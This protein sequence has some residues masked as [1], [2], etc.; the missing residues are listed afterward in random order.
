MF[1]GW[2]ELGHLN[3]KPL[4]KSHIIKKTSGE[5]FQKQDICRSAFPGWKAEQMQT[6]WQMIGGSRAFVSAKRI[7]VQNQT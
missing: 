7:A 3:M 2:R 1:Y 6:S 4:A 5:G